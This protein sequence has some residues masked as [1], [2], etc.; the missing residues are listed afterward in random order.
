MVYCSNMSLVTARVKEEE[1]QPYSYSSVKDEDR[2]DEQ[3]YQ[4][5][6]MDQLPRLP[7]IIHQVSKITQQPIT[8][9]GTQPQQL[10]KALLPQ[11]FPQTNLITSLA[12]NC[13]PV[14]M[15]YCMLFIT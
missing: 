11:Y 2:D 1:H 14:K 15:I 6:I 8:A 10:A 5:D 12:S 3:V 9:T 13:T 7:N 4:Q